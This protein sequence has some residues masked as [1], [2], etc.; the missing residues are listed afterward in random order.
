MAHI[1]NGVACYRC[2][3]GMWDAAHQHLAGPQASRV[4]PWGV[5][6]QPIPPQPAIPLPEPAP[7]APAPDADDVITISDNDE[8]IDINE[9]AGNATVT[10]NNATSSMAESSGMR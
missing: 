1:C 5:D 3:V 4:A 9:G 7:V 8:E 10:T 6:G 2:V